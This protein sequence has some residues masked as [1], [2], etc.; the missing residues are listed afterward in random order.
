MLKS[1]EKNT[2]YLRIVYKGRPDIRERFKIGQSALKSTDIISMG[3]FTD[4]LHA[5]ES[6][7]MQHTFALLYVKTEELI[8]MIVIL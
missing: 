2:F 1:F 3:R 7:T 6:T 5:S 8:L 4:L